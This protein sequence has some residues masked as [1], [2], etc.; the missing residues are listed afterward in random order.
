MISIGVTRIVGGCDDTGG[1]V[2]PEL[3][4]EELE[5]EDLVNSL[6]GDRGEK[7][8]AFRL[9]EEVVEVAEVAKDDEEEEEEEDVLRN[10]GG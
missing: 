10:K 6:G 5:A 1:V 8:T 2:D 3:E 7:S 9:S 4:A